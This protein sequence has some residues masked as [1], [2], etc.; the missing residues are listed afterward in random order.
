ME[1]MY[2]KKLSYEENAMQFY[3]YF[4]TTFEALRYKIIAKCKKLLLKG[5][6]GRN[7]LEAERTIYQST[8]QAGRSVCGSTIEMFLCFFFKKAGITTEMGIDGRDLCVY[9]DDGT[10]LYVNAKHTV[11]EK[12]NDNDCPIKVCWGYPNNS[13][14][15][16]SRQG[17]IEWATPDSI[18][19]IVHPEGRNDAQNVANQM[20]LNV[21]FLSLDSG[22]K[23]LK[24]GFPEIAVA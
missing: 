9:R 24:V 21:K 13:C 8:D 17:L 15:G 6:T 5:F 12:T 11:R 10:K 19:I 18:L 7:R 4:H 3:K 16:F 23:K 20:D 2:D 22:I 14:A 1:K